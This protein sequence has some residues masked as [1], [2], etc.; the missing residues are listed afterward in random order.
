M[1]NEEKDK[2]IL[3]DAFPESLNTD[4]RLSKREM[5]AAMC[6]QGLLANPELLKP[7]YKESVD[8]HALAVLNAD[9]LLTQL[10][11]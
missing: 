10:E 8:L 3:E 9:A 11:K 4:E 5:I 2:Q 7:E 6:L 1:T